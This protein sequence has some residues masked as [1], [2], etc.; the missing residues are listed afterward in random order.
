MTICFKGNSFK[1]EI[2]AIMKLFLPIK[3][4]E[5]LFEEEDRSGDF[6]VLTY[7]GG[8]AKC[9]VSLGGRFESEE[10]P[11]KDEAEVETALCRLLYDVMRKLTGITPPWGRLTGIRPVKKV[12]ALLDAGLSKDKIFSQLKSEYDVSDKKLELA[13]N[14]AI[15]Q[16]KYFD[17]LDKRSFSLYV[18]VPFCPSR[19]S[20][21]SF[22]SHSI[23]SS[24]AKKLLPEYTEKL[25]D[26][27]RQTAQIA[28][29]IG[30]K[31]DTIYIGGGTPTTLS[32]EQLALVMGEIKKSFDISKIREYTVEAGRSDTIT[33]KK[34][35]VIKGNG[36]T[37]ISVNPQT[38]NDDVLKAI[39]RRHTA[40]DVVKSFRLAREI[41][42]DNINMDTIAGLPTDTYE[43]FVHTIDE[44]CGLEPESITVHTLTLKRSSNLFH[45]EERCVDSRISDMVDYG[46]SKLFAEGYL[47]YYL[48]RQKN[49]IENLENVGYAKAGYES[50][51][52]IYIMEEAQTIFAVGAAGST[53]L[54]NTNTGKI[55]RLFNYKFPYEYISRYEKMLEKKDDIF[56]F[57]KSYLQEE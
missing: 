30:L 7:N 2:E 6:A 23:E 37:R 40:A 43:G 39:G 51:Y 36:A 55:E 13:Y 21:C 15:T 56:K 5:F 46:Q 29:E 42:F 1:Y 48:Y 50:L 10:A 24:S 19:C 34:L 8:S 9:E 41:G 20:Y 18:S 22:V 33:A 52:N 54:V 25:C 38:M 16:K 12:N 28:D 57:Y 17:T 53:K 49:T 47:P 3:T 4:F 11:V 27:I 26:E 35:E 45:E 14:T 32:A 44:L 31:L